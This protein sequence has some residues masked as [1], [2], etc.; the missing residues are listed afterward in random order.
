MYS[1]TKNLQLIIHICQ[2]TRN[3]DRYVVTILT[4]MKWFTIDIDINSSFK[5]YTSILKQKVRLKIIVVNTSYFIKYSFFQLNHWMSLS[6]F[7]SDIQPLKKKKVV[8]LYKCFKFYKFIYDYDCLIVLIPMLDHMMETI[9][10]TYNTNK[11]MKKF[12]FLFIVA[13]TVI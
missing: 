10:F 5:Q 6:L 13:V 1:L 2:L 7:R 8:K 11:T 3:L 12:L 4:W 9:D